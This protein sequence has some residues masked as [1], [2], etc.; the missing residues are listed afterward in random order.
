MSGFKKNFRDNVI[1]PY[2]KYSQSYYKLAEVLESDSK[3]NTCTISYVNLDGISVIS[4][5][6]PY[7]KGFLRG[8][9]GGFPKKGDYVEIQELNRSVKILD[10]IDINKIT[11]SDNPTTDIYSG[12]SSFSGNLGI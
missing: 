12:G 3:R 5:N 11:N 6:V 10:V 9:L 4:E 1:A 2:N 7:K 8:F